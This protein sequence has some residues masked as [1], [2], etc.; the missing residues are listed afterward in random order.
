M[1][2][3]CGAGLPGRPRGSKED[4]TMERTGQ[5]LDMD[6][7]ATMNE[8]EEQK[9]TLWTAWT[10]GRDFESTLRLAIQEVEARKL[11]CPELNV[12][13]PYHLGR[14]D[15]YTEL[16]EQLF[17]AK[18]RERAV[19]D[20]PD[21]KTG[22][23]RQILLA[24]YQVGEMRHGEL[25]EAVGSPCNSLTGIMKKVL[26]SGAVESVRSGRN[27]RYHLTEA[28]RQYCEQY[29]PVGDRLLQQIR[30]ASYQG[31][32]RALQSLTRQPAAPSR[33]GPRIGEWITPLWKNEIR[34]AMEHEVTILAAKIGD[35]LENAEEVDTSLAESVLATWQ[36]RKGCS[37]GKSE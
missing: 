36:M 8:I 4:V 20:E 30:E 35:G 25:A 9:E 21:L 18:E 10:E 13:V 28:G 1:R 24:L 27:T 11:E 6:L 22:K 29:L 14:L 23:A 34:D 2:K 15:G 12:S 5:A 7:Y 31:T 37:N 17:R 33:P 19:R 16:F 3:R 26:R 32:E